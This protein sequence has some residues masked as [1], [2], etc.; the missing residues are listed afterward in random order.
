MKNDIP[1]AAKRKR[2]KKK[3]GS[4]RRGT[5]G[6]EPKQVRRNDRKEQGK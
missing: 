4:D 3:K 5:H 2:G 1:F 6:R